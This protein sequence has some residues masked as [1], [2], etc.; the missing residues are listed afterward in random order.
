MAHQIS[1]NEGGQAE[2]A[3]AYKP[4]WHGLGVVVNSFMNVEEALDT[5]HLRWKVNKEPLYFATGGTV[6]DRVAVC[7]GDSGTYLGTVGKDWVPVQNEEQAK[8][9]EALTGLGAYVV[10]CVGAIRQGRRT[11]WTIKVPGAIVLPGNDKVDK[12][13]IVVNGHDGTLAFRAFWSP[14]RVVCNNTVNAA[15]SKSNDNGVS[16]YHRSKVSGHLEE[17]RALLG[18]ANKYYADLGTQFEHLMD[19]AFTD[20]EFKLYVD[21]VIP[22]PTGKDA[23]TPL[24]QEAR[25]CIASNYESGVGHEMAGKTAWGAYN[26]VTEYVCH[27]R[28]YASPT[29]RFE[30]LLLGGTKAVQQKAFDVALAMA[31]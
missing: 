2:A 15:L 6:P 23:F 7:R 26:A 31:E 10:E 1:I 25:H 29:R 22:K 4:A 13:L 16:L 5:A 12:Y 18:L 9:I 24:Q 27:Q 3:F 20:A 17:A 21:T 8:F 19:K 14:I 30:N 28:G 11:F